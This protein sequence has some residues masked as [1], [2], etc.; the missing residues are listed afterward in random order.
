MVLPPLH[1][2]LSLI[3]NDV[4]AMDKNGSEFSYVKEVFLKLSN[5]KIF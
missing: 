1:M 5:A 4:K 3:K 2:K